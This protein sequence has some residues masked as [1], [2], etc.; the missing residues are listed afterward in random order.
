MLK[1]M[2][3]FSLLSCVE[4]LSRDLPSERFTGD[5]FFL[6]KK[7]PKWSSSGENMKVWLKVLPM[8]LAS[9][10]YCE[11]GLVCRM[12]PSNV[13]LDETVRVHR[14]FFSTDKSVLSRLA[15][16]LFFGFSKNGSTFE[17]C[18]FFFPEGIGG[19]LRDFFHRRVK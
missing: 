13:V 18:L 6:R 2:F 5:G 3:V 14:F 4:S 10:H 16:F 11:M 8:Q 17:Q 1:L 19:L 7:F 15:Y 9:R 12:L